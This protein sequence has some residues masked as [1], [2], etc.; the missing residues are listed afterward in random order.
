LD[1]VSAILYLA[2]SSVDGRVLT[3]C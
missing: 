3:E 2:D 1:I